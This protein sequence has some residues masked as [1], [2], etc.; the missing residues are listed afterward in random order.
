M[1]YFRFEDER[2]R[3]FGKAFVLFYVTAT[4]VRDLTNLMELT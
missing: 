1:I 4:H 3:F 2:G